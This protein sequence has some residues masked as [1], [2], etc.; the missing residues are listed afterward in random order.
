[1]RFVVLGCCLV[2]LACSS[3]Q[4]AP[5]LYAASEVS[6]LGLVPPGYEAGEAVTARCSLA[7]R[8]SAFE[9]EALDNV[10]CNVA[11]LSRVLRAKAGQVSAPF[12]VEKQCRARGSSERPRLDCSARVAR[13][14]GRVALGPI[15]AA[16]DGPAPSPAQVL[17]WDDPRPQDAEQVRVSFEPWT[18]RPARRLPPRAYD[19]VAET[20][21]PSVGRQ[22]LGQVS[23][24]CAA[25]CTTAELRY[26]LRVTAGH[27]GAGEVAAVK[28]FSDAGSPRCVATA[29][30][31]WSS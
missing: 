12:I 21:F 16:D 20:A 6:E 5:K 23:A 17:D 4:Q 11:R 27:V 8:S 1:M 28:C 30:V 10:D 18:A 9:D 29:L 24:R 19:R 15:P 2:S 3:S 22:A 7:P 31:P 14:S 25:T 13:Q 26:A